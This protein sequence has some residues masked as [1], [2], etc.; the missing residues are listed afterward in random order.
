MPQIYQSELSRP[1][2]EAMR[3]HS[4]V[5]E[6]TIVNLAR[7]AVTLAQQV[8][9]VQRARGVDSRQLG[10][11]YTVSQSFAMKYPVF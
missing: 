9:A 2:N 6:I 1:I 3:N 8:R 5:N 4:I 7:L 11:G 10:E